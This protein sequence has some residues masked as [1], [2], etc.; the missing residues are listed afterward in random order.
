MNFEDKNH[1]R[2]AFVL[3]NH[4]VLPFEKKNGATEESIISSFRELGE[5][6]PRQCTY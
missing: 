2:C 1:C 6:M 5:T 4:C 3:R